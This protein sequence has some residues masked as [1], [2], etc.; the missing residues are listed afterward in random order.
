MQIGIIGHGNVGGALARNW[1]GKGHQ[2]RIGARDPKGEK[3]K[4]LAQLNNIESGTIPE[5]TQ[6]SEVILVA[7]PA[8]EAPDL[9]PKLGDLSGKILIDS[10]NSIGPSSGPYPT[11]FHAFQA[12]TEAEV[13]KCFNSTGYENMADPI[14]EGEGIDMFMAGNSTHAKE[15]ARQLALDAGFGNCHDFGNA[16][17]VKLLEQLAL[18]WINLAI[19]QKQGRNIAFKVLTRQGANT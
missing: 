18:C 1:A 2:I 6:S 7:I 19:F 17:Q 16:E 15:V 5:T 10:T 4:A 8:R 3:V 9:A 13:V 14:Y 12:L 11:A